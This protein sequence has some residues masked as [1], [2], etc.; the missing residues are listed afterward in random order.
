MVIESARSMGI[1]FDSYCDRQKCIHNPYDLLFLGD[2]S[3]EI[4]K[5]K[6][7][8]VGIGDNRIRE[9]IF[10]SYGSWG[11]CL[12]IRDRSAHVSSSA[13]IDIGTF[14]A[15]NVVVNA[16]AQIGAGVILN[17]SS[18]VEHECMIGDFAH[19]APGAVLA[20]NVQ[21]GKR[22]FVGANS[23]IKEGIIIGDNAIIG[24][25]TVIIKDVPDGC[26]VVG[27]PG[28]IIRKK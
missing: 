23:V 11:T 5:D 1:S 7:W 3:T 17:S 10:H 21:V 27:N 6:N 16:H 9:K 18:V 19:V 12:T 20:G 26:T 15:P 22:S 24:A 8:F 13:K 28:R 14:I 2:E 25:G 4:L